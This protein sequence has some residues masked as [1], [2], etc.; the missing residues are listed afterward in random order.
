MATY[1][2]TFSGRPACTLDLVVTE[3]STNSAANTSVVSWTLNVTGNSAS[4]NGGAGS[5]SVAVNG[6]NWSGTWNYDFRSNNNPQIGS[7]STT[8]THLTNGSKTISSSASATDNGSSPLGTAS[9]SGSLALTDFTFPPSAPPTAPTF[10]RTSDGVT[11]TVTSAVA[12]SAA[13]ITDYQYRSS[14]DGSAWGSTVSMGTDRVATFTALSTQ[15]YFFQTRAISSEG[16]GAWS[17]SGTTAGVPSAPASITTTRSARDVTVNV[18]AS[19][20]N[21]G[22]TITGYFFQYSTDS[23]STWSTAVATTGS[24]HTF[25]GLTAGLTYRFRAY[26]TN[27]T[28]SSAFTTATDL[29][30]PAGGRRYDG[31]S[32]ASTGTAKRYDGTNWVDLATAKRWNGSSWVDLS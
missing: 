5:W 26:A 14:T 17:S 22:S 31:T 8:V 1:S 16:N 29:F 15:Q 10:S 24:T 28:G 11:V 12:S 4:Y 30:V 25:T 6:V 21:G 13:T 2:G 27:V 23:G 20:S 7:G 32:W 19:A 9:S 18:G 3:S